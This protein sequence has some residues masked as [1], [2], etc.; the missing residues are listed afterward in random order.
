MADIGSTTRVFRVCGYFIEADDCQEGLD[1]LNHW[2]SCARS[3][4]DL[5]VGTYWVGHIDAVD[6]LPNRPW[7][8][9]SASTPN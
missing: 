8:L 9:R 3:I 2:D 6:G 1:Y 5:A 4:L 7:T